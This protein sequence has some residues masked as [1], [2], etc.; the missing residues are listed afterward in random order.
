MIYR[1][2]E[3]TLN[4]AKREVHRGA[5]A[6]KIEPRTYEL[7]IYLLENRDR[8]IGKDE[9]QDKV[10]GT[11]VSDSAMTRGVMKLRKS[12][13]D[14]S[15]AIIKTVPRFGYRFVAEV[16]SLPEPPSCSP[17]C[18]ATPGSS[19]QSIRS[20]SPYYLSTT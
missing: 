1:F 16:E 2:E 6:V 7:L 18:F 13:G 19:R 3:F 9:L 17:P 4:T 8:A 5:E 10:W 15:D 14:T 11:I 20:P 12:L